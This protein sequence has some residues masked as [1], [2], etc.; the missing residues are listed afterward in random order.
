MVMPI[1]TRSQGQ[2]GTRS[3]AKVED[4]GIRGVLIDQQ[5]DL[6]PVDS[7]A[8]RYFHMPSRYMAPHTARF[9]LGNRR[10]RTLTGAANQAGGRIDVLRLYSGRKTV[11]NAE[12]V[13]PQVAL[14]Q[15]TRANENP[16]R[17][18]RVS[19]SNVIL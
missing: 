19:I 11:V 4:S 9:S 8:S 2:V 10:F 6:G 17:R 18:G 12:Q 7:D 3:A 5:K 15:S 16:G 14:F 13:R 1:P